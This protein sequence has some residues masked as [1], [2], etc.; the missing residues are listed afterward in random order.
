LEN[1]GGVGAKKVS[2][3]N[4]YISVGRYGGFRRGTLT[5]RLNQETLNPGR[6]VVGV[7][8][9]GGGEE[10]KTRTKTE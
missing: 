4:N 5:K 9:E 7:I 3:I 6:P 2:I 1:R 10:D 8:R